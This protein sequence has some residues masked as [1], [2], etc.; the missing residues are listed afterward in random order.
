[1]SSYNGRGLHGQVVDVVGRRIVQGDYPQGVTLDL[2]NLQS[3]HGVSLTVIRESLKVLAA[4][5]LVDARQRRGTFVQPRS[6]WN[7]LDPDILTWEITSANL[8]AKLDQLAEIRAIFEP[9]SAALAAARCDEHDVAAIRAAYA[10][11]ESAEDP[12]DATQADL[13]FHR[14]VLAATRNDLLERVEMLTRSL[15]AERDRL[16]HQHV[17][18]GKALDLHR[19]LLDAIVAGDPAAARSASELLLGRA[20]ADAATTI[21]H[22]SPGD[23]AAG[24]APRTQKAS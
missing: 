6:S 8:P 19:A 12:A 17:D 20:L 15:F 3:E 5:G 4:K 10:A 1:M 13:D 2:E 18:P 16:V 24:S 9:A 23:A 7:L 21:E 22:S 11:M 14:A